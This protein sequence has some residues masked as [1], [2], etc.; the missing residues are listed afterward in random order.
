MNSNG[1]DGF[2][3][4]IRKCEGIVILFVIIVLTNRV[5]H[6]LSPKFN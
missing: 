1:L 2:N 4:D 6:R 5:W 3:Q